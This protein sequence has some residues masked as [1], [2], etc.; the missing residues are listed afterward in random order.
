MSKIAWTYEDDNGNEITR[1]LPATWEICGRC[2]GDG[3]HSH[4]LGA[5]TSSEWAEWDCE[6]RDDY[7]AG[8]YDR[9]C[10]ECGGSGKIL[11]V[12]EEEL[13]RRD[14]ELFERWSKSERDEAQYQ[15]MC[16]A[17]REMGA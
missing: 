14:P 15:A 13:K 4:D 9:E 16:R 7:M 1:L 12:D 8:R 10:E 2:N 17:E 11:E 3:K 5:I 6:E